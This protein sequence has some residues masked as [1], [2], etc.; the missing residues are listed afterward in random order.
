MSPELVTVEEY[1]YI[2]SLGSPDFQCV[3][4]EFSPANQG[5]DTDA[6]RVEP[7]EEE[8]EEGGER[9][10]EGELSVLGHQC[11]PLSLV[12]ECRGSALI[13]LEMLAPVVLCHK[14]P[15][16]VPTRGFGTQKSG[17]FACSSLAFYG[18]KLLA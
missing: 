13:G 1:Q 11:A 10:G 2:F 12:E 4:A 18:T 9:G 6:C 14:E 3:F 16:P 17:F 8:S 7:D 15:A 5:R